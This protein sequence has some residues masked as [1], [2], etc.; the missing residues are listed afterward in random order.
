[1]TPARHR[2]HDRTLSDGTS[3]SAAIRRAVS[4][5][6][7]AVLGAVAEVFSLAADAVS[8]ADADVDAVRGVEVAAL[9]QLV[10]LRWKLIARHKRRRSF[11]PV[12]AS[13]ARQLAFEQLTLSA[14]VAVV[15]LPR[16]R[17]QVDYAAFAASVSRALFSS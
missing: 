2:A 5:R 11:E 12:A 1:I 13:R 8:A 7:R 15:S 16:S 3:R 4:L 6:T 14:A 9:G 17:G 10:G